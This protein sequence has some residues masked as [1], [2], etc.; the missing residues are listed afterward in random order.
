MAAQP[1]DRII[2][3]LINSEGSGIGQANIRIAN[4]NLRSQ[5]NGSFEVE[6][7]AA[8][9]HRLHITAVGY[10]D[11]TATITKEKGEN[12]NLQITLQQQNNLI[13][14]VAVQGKTAFQKLKEQP[15]R[16]IMIDTKAVSE[17]P[18]TLAEVMNRASGIRIRQSGGLGNQVDVSINGFQG[19]AVQYFRD[20]IPLTYLGGGYGINNVPINQLRQVEIYKGVVP[21]SLGGDALGG[22]VNLVSDQSAANSLQASYEAASFKTHIGN[23]SWRQQFQKKWFAGVDAFI[24]TS[25]NNYKVDVEIVNENANLEPARVRLFHNAYRHYFTEAYL[26]VKDKKWAD[27]LRLSLALYSIDR[28]SQHP[29]LMTNPYGAIQLTNKGFVPSIRYKKTLWNSRI[30][31]D[32]FVSYS[33]THRTRTDTIK[34]TYDWYG[35]FTA[36]T[37][38]GESPNPSL[39]HIDYTHIISR[40]AAS[41]SIDKNNTIYTSFTLDHNMRKGSDPLGFRFTGTDVD[42][43]SK[44]A[45]YRKSILGISWESNWWNK[46]L[47]NQLFVKH[48]GFSAKGINGFLSNDTDLS[49]YQSMSD[50]NFG[51]GNATKY[52]IDANSFVRASVELTNRLPLQEELFGNNDTRAPNF[53]LK[54][55][56]S[57][58]VNLGYRYATARYSAEIGTF[59]R[60]TKGMILLV[61]IQPPFSQYKNLDSIQGYGFD[62]D[63]SYRLLKNVE[64]SGNATW[65]D[66]R[67]V[68]VGEPLYKWIEGTRLTNTPYFFSNIGVKGNFEHVFSKND[69]LKPYIHYNFI[70]EFYLVNVPKDKEANG[71]LGLTGSAKISTKDLVPNQSLINAGFTYNFPFANWTFGAEVKNIMDAKLYDYY[72][73]Q[74]PGRSIH[75]KINYFIKS[76]KS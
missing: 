74:R 59:Y 44:K 20:G 13:E 76:T 15:I 19:N 26:G 9:K 28:A 12:L 3:L 27:E 52:Q 38:V 14:Q 50:F 32:Q 66:I 22:A 41:F 45:T 64:I 5:H 40:T 49:K 21:I 10:S 67:M 4:Q 61:P 71:F 46:K 72:K 31:I 43:L 11:Y 6:N 23:I 35:N 51:Y 54:P 60:K 68:D 47:T 25:A 58:N 53:N 24:N 75:F 37:S 42:I 34:G 39:A 69:G 36:G 16:A 65:Q 8:G 1:T 17:Q 70:R 56:R 73:I 57:F 48:F 29:A 18:T 30:N 62:I 63:L 33:E 7:I 55:E 2:G